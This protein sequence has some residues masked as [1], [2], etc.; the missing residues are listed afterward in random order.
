VEEYNPRTNEWIQVT[1]METRRLQFG[2][3]VVASKLYV[4][5][6]LLESLCFFTLANLYIYVF[7]LFNTEAKRAIGI[8]DSKSKKK[9]R[10]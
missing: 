10:I 8:K 9:L 3:A 4:T 6:K 1:T 2:V 5:G 7:P